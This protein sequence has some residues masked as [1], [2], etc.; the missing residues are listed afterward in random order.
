MWTQQHQLFNHYATRD[1]QGN[2]AWIIKLILCY[3]INLIKAIYHL[4]I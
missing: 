4:T 3:D 1:A 2:I